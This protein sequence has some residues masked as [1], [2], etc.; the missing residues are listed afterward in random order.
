[1]R[2]AEKAG[3]ELGGSFMGKA[4]GSMGWVNER[5]ILSRANFA[6]LK[7]MAT[8]MDIAIL[9]MNHFKLVAPLMV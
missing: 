6:S 5:Q 2:E 9:Q 1:M 7:S 8:R 4:V 3:K